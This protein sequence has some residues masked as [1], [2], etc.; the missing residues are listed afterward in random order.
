MVIVD[1]ASLPEA[2]R[3][4]IQKGIKRPLLMMV[5]QS[6]GYFVGTAETGA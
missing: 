6:D 3:R 4:A 2:R 5:P 1:G